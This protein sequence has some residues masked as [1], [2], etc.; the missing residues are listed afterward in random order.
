MRTV[1]PR[2][3]LALALGQLIAVPAIGVAAPPRR[4]E[5]VCLINQRG[6]NTLVFQEVDP[7]SPGRAVALRGFY[8]TSA[9]RASAVSG[10]AVMVTDGSVRLGL[11]VHS[12][13]TPA[14]NGAFANDFTL[15][16]VIDAT[17]TGNLFHDNDGDFLPDGTLPFEVAD[18]ATTTIR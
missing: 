9:G 1:N 18:C 3:S 11:F 6:L 8:F 7:L 13:A 10:S 5:D 14:P 12:S 15:S 16:G 4:A 2:E 17:L